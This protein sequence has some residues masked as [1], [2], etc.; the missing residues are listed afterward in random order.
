[1][2]LPWIPEQIG[3]KGNEYADRLAKQGANMEQE[4]LT[5]TLKE[6]KKQ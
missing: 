4:K 1:M 2:I 6:E 3:I 5:I